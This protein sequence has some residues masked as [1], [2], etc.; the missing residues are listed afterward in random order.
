MYAD[1]FVHGKDVIKE[2]SDRINTFDGAWLWGVKTYFSD[3]TESIN[4]DRKSGIPQDIKQYFQQEN[5][6][7]VGKYVF[8]H[9]IKDIVKKVTEEKEQAFLSDVLDEY[10]ARKQLFF[11]EYGR[12]IICSK[13]E[14]EITLD[15][16]ER[17][18]R[19]M[20]EI[21]GQKIGDFESFRFNKT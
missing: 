18:I 13:I 1:Y 21:Q 9:N 5:Y 6:S 19:A 2:L 8:D 12:G 7:L 16:T 3:N 20:E 10:I 14:D 4:V 17:V 11:S 15:R